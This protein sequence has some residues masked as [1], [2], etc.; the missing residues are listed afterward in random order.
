MPAGSLPRTL[1]VVVDQR[2]E[3]APDGSA[4]THTPPS[5]QFFE[6]TL[7]VFESVRV[8]ARARQVDQPSPSARRVDGPRV[9]IVAV[10]GFVGPFEYLMHRGSVQE[11]LD[12][13][14]Q[15]EGAFL[16]R[17]P[18][19]TG[20]LL[21]ERLERLGR[22][23]AVE[24]LTDPF[25]FFSPGVSPHGLARWF[26]PY[27]CRRCKELA[28]R[29]VAVNFV[30]GTRT[31]DAHPAPSARFNGQVSDVELPSEAFLPARMERPEGV[32]LRIIT[33][34]FL[35]LLYKGQDLLL[36]ALARFQAE[37]LRFHLTFAG[38]GENRGRLLSLAN[39]LGIA[40]SVTIT[41]ALGGP[42]QVRLR[43]AE[44]DL[45]V[46]P[47]RAEGIPRAL[48]EAMAAGLPAI[49]SDVGAM[50]DLLDPRWIVPSGDSAALASKL[51]EMHS[52][53]SEWPAI[54]A[55]N[56]QRARAF[57]SSFI[58][59]QRLAFYEA[60]SR[61]TAIRQREEATNAA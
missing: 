24:L 16:L 48:I 25:D 21:A 4:W 33:V 41:G 44:S 58:Q 17:I 50:P 39:S 43:L 8:I 20:F 10:P 52:A 15:L 49:G 29:A 31:R 27:F 42:E 23:Y 46:L 7:K 22:G 61:A 6:K 14:A 45:F 56:Q 19:K 1:N 53:R 59:P 54:G 40:S 57:E 28:S 13:V 3:L 26:R 11:A 30:T 9:S 60:I 37:G 2:F 32:P 18:S 38:D 5:Y 12:Q 35:D 55:A 34:G 47:S 36:Q 51:M